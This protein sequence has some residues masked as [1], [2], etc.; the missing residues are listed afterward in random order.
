MYLTRMELDVRKTET[1]KALVS[2]NLLH[3]AVEHALPEERGRHLWRIDTLGG[4]EYLMI[5]SAG[6]PN[7]GHAMDQF[8]KNGTVPETKDYTPLL[9]RVQ[10]GGVWHF[11]LV[12][13][14][15]KTISRTRRVLSHITVD[16]Q[17]KWLLDRSEKNGFHLENDDFD[18]TWTK[19]YNFLKS[20]L[21][22]VQ[23]TAAAFDGR[24]II[25][26]VASFRSALTE[27]IG[28]ERAYGMGL[29][30]IVGG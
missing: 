16:Y 12:A 29:L 17:K 5:L 27:G 2:P 7:L 19:R 28:R 24:L 1:M 18:V 22:R 6:I 30:T 4:R 8:G 20:G 9:N 15:A 11:R 25:S 26:D 23:F 14:P 21:N 10:K 13:N 3:G